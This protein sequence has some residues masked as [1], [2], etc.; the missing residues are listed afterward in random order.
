MNRLARNVAAVIA[1]FVGCAAA[2]ASEMSISGLV[3]LG[4]M[5]QHRGGE[6]TVTMEDGMNS[7]SCIDLRGN[8]ELGNGMHARFYLSS[9]F[10]ADNGS[11]FNEGRLFDQSTVSVGGTW[12]DLYLGRHGSVKS[13]DGDQSNFAAVEGFSPMGSNLPNTGLA[14]VFLTGG[15]LNNS[16]GWSSA[17]MGGHKVHVQYS[18]GVTTETGRAGDDDRL[19]S[20]STTYNNGGRIRWGAIATWQ[21]HNSLAGDHDPTKDVMVSMNYDFESFRLYV[22]YQHVWN[23]IGPNPM[24]RWTDFGFAADAKGFDTD[25]LMIGVMK[26]LWGG[27]LSAVVQ[28]AHSKFNGAVDAGRDDSGWRLNPAF[29]YRYPVSIRTTLWT[30]ASWTH[31]WGMFKDVAED[32][33]DDPNTTTWGC[34]L[35]HY[36]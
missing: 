2:Q 15:T 5:A 16:I 12:G 22:T 7:S 24:L 1:V 18:N 25:S 29:I 26:E 21:N 10:T 33:Y 23:G 4:F 8:E 19:I 3:D 34:G 20:V 35:T 31:G 17:S 36:F 13:P 32:A 28:G 30:S 14:W 6:T 27:R 11:F 9:G